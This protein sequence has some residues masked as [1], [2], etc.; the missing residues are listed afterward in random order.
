MPKLAQPLSQQIVARAKPAE[1]AYELRDGKVTGL[2]LRVNPTGNKVWAV[3]LRD[4]RRFPLG[5]ADT[6]KDGRRSPFDPADVLTLT[7]ARDRATAYLRA[8]GPPEAPVPE[9]ETEAPMDDGPLTLGRYLEDRYRPWF[10][11]QRDTAK[12]LTNLKWFDVRVNPPA[13]TKLTSFNLYA[14]PLVEIDRARVD[15]WVT[16]RLERVGKATVRRNVTALK[17]ALAQ[18]F[19]W[20]LLDRNP[21]AGYGAVKLADDPRTRFLSLEEEGVL[22]RVLDGTNPQMRALVLLAINTGLRKGELYNLKWEDVDLGR[23][24]L[25][26]RGKTAKSRR[27][28]HVPLSAVAHTLL[29]GLDRVEGNPYVFRGRRGKRLVNIDK[30]FGRLLAKAGIED[31]SFHCLRHTFASRLVGKGVPLYAVQKLLGHSD[32]KLTARYSH[33]APDAL[34]AA[35][36]VLDTPS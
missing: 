7:D 16:Q 17:A 18:A 29:S 4:G 9:L 23:R 35:V 5:P 30:A 22:R 3:R 13:R 20:E 25:A 31:A 10:E 26:V 11:S 33:L 21:L 8:G 32:P 24:V 6:L 19:R 27:L 1:R 15:L 14:L 36:A 2:I 12:A 28:R 34:A